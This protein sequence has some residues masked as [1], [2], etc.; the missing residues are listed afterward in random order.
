LEIDYRFQPGDDDDGLTISVPKEGLQQLDARRLE[1]LVPGRVQEKLTALIRSLPK[2]V[3]RSFIPAPDVARRAAEMMPFAEGDF[4]AVAAQTL[5][6]IG[7]EPLAASDFK[8]NKLPHHL[9]MNVRVVG[10]SGNP[11]AEGRDIDALAAEV[12]IEG[13]SGANVVSDANWDRK[14]IRAWDFG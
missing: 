5:S 12:G 9:R 1:W 7:G 13:P 8:L 3:R 6:K 14:G 4:L 11:V 2:A 10:E